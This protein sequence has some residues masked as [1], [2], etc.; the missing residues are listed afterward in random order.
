MNGAVEDISLRDKSRGKK[1][2]QVGSLES[3][4]SGVKPHVSLEW[5]PNRRRVIAKREQIGLSWRNFRRFVEP[6]P[7]CHKILA[8]AFD[9]PTGLFELENFEDVLSYEVI[10]LH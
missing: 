6:P 3:N 10:E 5:E 4:G 1:K 2:K 8:D 7:R 9:V